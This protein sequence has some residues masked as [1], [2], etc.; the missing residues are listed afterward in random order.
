M[1]WCQLS[2]LWGVILIQ[3]IPAII[4]TLFSLSFFWQGTAQAGPFFVFVVDR[5]VVSSNAAAHAKPGNHFGRMQ[6]APRVRYAVRA[7]PPSLRYLA[8]AENLP[9]KISGRILRNTNGRAASS[10]AVKLLDTDGTLL[11][12]TKT[13]ADGYFTIDLG[14][15]DSDELVALMKFSL[16]IT[17]GTGNKYIVKL[18]DKALNN[19]GKIKLRDIIAP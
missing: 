6:V 13:D 10:A 16:E 8:Q 18:Q 19:T 9:E 11:D 17:T 12:A 2:I 5:H 15:L 4:L 3:V 7:S 14:V 1:S